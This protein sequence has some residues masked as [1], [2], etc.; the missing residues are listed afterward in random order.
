MTR[1]ISFFVGTALVALAVAAPAFGEG[2]LAGSIEP[3]DS[4][5]QVSRPDS[6]DI[7]RAPETTY[8]DAADRA[9]RIDVVVPTA[10]T[11]AFDRAAPPKGTQPTLT[12]GAVSDDGIEWSQLGFGFGL[13]ILLVAGLWL[14]MRMT[15]V[16]PLAH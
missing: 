6:H 7:F 8:L 1:R 15:R 12:V 14:A 10:Y 11:D 4:V 3:Q 16:R 13:G 5:T 9:Q 2:R